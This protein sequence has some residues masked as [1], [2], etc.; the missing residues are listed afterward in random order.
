M[1]KSAAVTL[2]LLAATP[3]AC[4]GDEQAASRA[5]DPQ[6]ASEVQ[7]EAAAFLE[8][9]TRTFQELYYESSLAS[10][11]L[12]TRIVEG[13]TTNAARYRRAREAQAAFEG[14]VENIERVTE[15]L[16]RRDQLTPLQTAQLAAIAYGAA[17]YPGT[18]PELVAERIAAEAEQVES[19]FG[20]EFRLNG[21]PITPNEIDELLRASEDL[22]ERRAVWEAS[23]EVGPALREGIVRLQRLR[24]GT[25]QALGYP[26]YFT[27]Q[28]SEYGMPPAEMLELT[29]TL[30]R[31]LRPLYRELHTWVRYE[32]AARY[33]RPVPDLIPAHWLPNRWA[34]DW[35][36]LVSVEGLD[37]GAALREQTPEWIV[38][39][40]EQFYL[41]LGFEP[42]PGSFWENSS[43]YPLP[44]DAP[45]KKNTHAS[46][47]HLDRADDIRSLMSVEP[48]T[49]WWSTTLHEL[50]HIYYYMTY[51]TPEV[52]LLLRRGANRGYHEAIGSLM[53][54][55]SLQRPFLVG[56]GLVPADAQVDA[57]AQLLKEALDHVISIPWAAGTMTRFEAA[58]YMD[59]L[60]AE[61]FNQRW[62]ELVERYQGVAP[63]EPRGEEYADAL[64]KT[65]ISNDAAQYYDYAISRALLFQMHDHIARN[66]LQQDPHETNYWG[67]AAV[68]DFL[69]EVMAPG[70]SRPW[71]E[72]LMETTGRELDAQAMVEYF[73]PLYDWLVEQND[74]RRHTLP[75]L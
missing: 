70:M 47:W 61:Q 43:L 69:R 12:N 30:V 6:P 36:A 29:E 49:E 74:G 51:S 53:G 34:Q 66:I 1:R 63:P 54:L 58:L 50:G 4:E 9:Y 65:H 19:L 48:N 44:P 17:Q 40:G 33:G 22:E 62:W 32:L 72:V 15:L 39:R 75:Q 41:S 46:A 55:A 21:R 14:S 18:V 7:R 59:P 68:G 28:V 20:F 5:G 64:S 11:A 56:Q 25:V 10:W 13:D 71:P 27:Y 73:Q 26:D 3:V 35:S 8:A 52:P 2:V 31:Q 57:M 45:Y 60:P 37:P 67:S 16:V 42:L 38:E 24:N 23:K